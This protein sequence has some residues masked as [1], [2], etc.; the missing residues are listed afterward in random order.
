MTSD[1]LFWRLAL[2]SRS[3]KEAALL[4]WLAAVRAD[5]RPYREPQRHLF[6]RGLGLTRSDLF[7][8][9]TSLA[10]E[11]V[12]STEIR[13]SCASFFSLLPE[14]LVLKLWK[15]SGPQIG[16]EGP[17]GSPLP[18]D[19]LL[20]TPVFGLASA[21]AYS[22]LC[23]LRRSL[24]QVVLLA[25]LHQLGAGSHSI[26]ISGRGL[27]DRSLRLVDRYT[28]MREVSRLQRDGLVVVTPR[29]RAGT[30]Y[31]LN[32]DALG[33]MLT[34]APASSMAFAATPGWAEAPFPLLQRLDVATAE[35]AQSPE[36][37]PAGVC[38]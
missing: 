23:M 16:I 22:R 13:A 17:V 11:G 31:R 36:A 8:L 37:A 3:I 4:W 35:A 1:E 33:A 7:R 27:E 14:K 32:G 26:V 30:E 21:T 38:A 18:F 28:V 19:P 6:A 25:C 20:A 9:R 10:A 29:G 15:G 2:G 24:E 12:L 5:E 34:S